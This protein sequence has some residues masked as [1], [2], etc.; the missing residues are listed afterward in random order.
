LILAIQIRSCPIHRVVDLLLPHQM[1][2]KNLLLK[3]KTAVSMMMVVVTFAV[4]IVMLSKMRGQRNLF[5]SGTTIQ[6]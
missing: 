4:Q 3:K 6:I 1:S 5:L 2:L